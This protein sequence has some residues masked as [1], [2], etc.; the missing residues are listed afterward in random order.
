VPLVLCFALF[1]YILAALAS[2][3]LQTYRSAFL[4]AGAVVWGVLL[5]L[6]LLREVLPGPVL[7]IAHPTA[8]TQ[9]LM[10]GDV[11]MGSS[12]GTF[13]LVYGAL[14]ALMIGVMIRQYRGQVR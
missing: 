12:I 2:L 9:G 13:V 4:L 6:P 7:W 10:D 8:L 3:N 5:G 14:T 1:A 11:R